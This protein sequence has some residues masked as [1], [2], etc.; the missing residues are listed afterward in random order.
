MAGTLYDGMALIDSSAVIA[1][2]DSTE[3]LHH[4][5]RQFYEGQSGLDWF[6]VNVTSHE[7]FTR[8]RY[9]GDG[10][11]AAL[12]RYDFLRSN[13]VR[14]LVFTDEDEIAARQTLAMYTDQTLSFH[15]ALCA[16]VMHRMGIFKIFTFDSDFWILG[17]EVLPGVTAPRAV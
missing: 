13:G 6:A 17:F 1:L 8:T 2:R 14:V 9:S 3:P 16:A 7:T 10:L 12:S 4:T 15:D 11:A 5:A